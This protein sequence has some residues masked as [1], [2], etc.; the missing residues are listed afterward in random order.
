[1]LGRVKTG[2]DRRGQERKGHDRLGWVRLCQEGKSTGQNGSWHVK[3]GQDG[4]GRVKGV[5]ISVSY[6]ASAKMAKL[7]EFKSW[8]LKSH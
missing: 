1:M 5:I 7:V 3:T 6:I 2:Q 4:S 8:C